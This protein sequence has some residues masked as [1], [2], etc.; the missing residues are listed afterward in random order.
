RVF[1]LSPWAEEEFDTARGYGLIPEEVFFTDYT[2]VISRVD[3]CAIIVNLYEKLDGKAYVAQ[4]PS[5][6]ADTFNNSV[7]KAYE[8]GIV[9]G[10]SDDRFAPYESITRQAAATILTNLMSARNLKFTVDSGLLEGFGDAGDIADWAANSVAVMLSEGYMRGTGDTTFS[11]LSDIS[12]EQAVLL[13]ARFFLNHNT[14][15]VRNKISVTSVADDT[16]VPFEDVTLAW[17]RERQTAKDGYTVYLYNADSYSRRFSKSAI[18]TRMTLTAGSDFADNAEYY[19]IVQ[20][21]DGVYS[22][23]IHIYTGERNI[24]IKYKNSLRP[25]SDGILRLEWTGVAEA[26]DYVVEI[27]EKRDSYNE[28]IPPAPFR[29]E[30]TG[31]GTEFSFPAYYNCLYEIKVYAVDPN[32]WLYDFEDTAIAYGGR[33]YSLRKEDFRF[34]EENPM[35]SKETADA[36]MTTIRVNV[37]KLNSG[38]GKVASTAS[39]TVHHRIADAVAAV[40]EEIFNGEEQFP[41]KDVGG[42][43][44]RAPMSS[45][46]LSEH[47][48]GTAIDINTNENYCV[49]AD[50]TTIGG[51]W[52]PYENPYS[53]TP[54]GEVVRI[55]EKH[56][57]T[58][59]GDAW[60]NPYDYMHFSYFGT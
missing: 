10:V 8:L 18:E 11:P 26:Y 24:R 45:G 12:T 17:E 25:D 48:Y 60:G 20:S 29:K 14:T 13:A 28:N 52:S 27:Q 21:N 55:F 33:P 36:Q 41:I 4:N 22:K 16:F 1:N 6:F 51:F 38:G 59:G 47:N 50:G 34:D 49:Y 42:Y 15:E 43:N 40:F 46:R 44:W 37:W 58:W 23:P 56:G 3:F 2:A 57:F 9:S 5:P 31:G 35:N 19:I 7:R 39:L 53:I 30:K 32:D 54:Y